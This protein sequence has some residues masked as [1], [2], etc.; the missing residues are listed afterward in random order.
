M[1]KNIPNKENLRC[2]KVESKRDGEISRR[3]RELKS[4]VLSRRGQEGDKRVVVVV[5]VGSEKAV[6]R[7]I[8]DSE[9]TPTDSRENLGR[10]FCFEIPRKR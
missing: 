8:A 6:W 5:V 2:G 1:A 9:E 4:R 7:I 3:R 10:E